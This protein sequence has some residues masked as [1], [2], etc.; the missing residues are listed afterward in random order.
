MPGYTCVV[1]E[2]DMKSFPPKYLCTCCGNILRDPVQTKC[3][4]RYCKSCV[5][6][7]LRYFLANWPPYYVLVLGKFMIS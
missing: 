3:G 4:H 5:E 1:S 7:L 2:K 6:P